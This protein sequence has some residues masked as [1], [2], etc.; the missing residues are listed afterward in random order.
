MPRTRVYEAV[1]ERIEV[2]DV[3]GKV[4]DSLMPDLGD[5]QGIAA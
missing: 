3:E 4:D 5:D 2:L 1:T